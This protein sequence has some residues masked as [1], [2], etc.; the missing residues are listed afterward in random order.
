M[1]TLKYG[2][3]L[4]FL[5]TTITTNSG[6]EYEL[7]TL[8]WGYQAFPFPALY[9]TALTQRG[10]TI[11]GGS[12]Y[13]D[14]GH[15]VWINEIYKDYEN[16]TS[17]VTRSWF[18]YDNYTAFRPGIHI[19]YGFTPWAA[20]VGRGGMMIDLD[21]FTTPTGGIGLK[22]STPWQ[23]YACGSLIL[24]ADYPNLF[25]TT[26]L[27]GGVT[28]KGWELLTLG[29][30]SSV[31]EITPVWDKEHLL[32]GSLFFFA[33]LH[34]LKEMHILGGISPGLFRPSIY[35]GLGYTY[36]IAPRTKRIRKVIVTEEETYT[37]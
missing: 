24:E 36:N 1:N 5:L 22:L 12:A 33:N 18:N 6:Q 2:L 35:L 26:V 14:I 21:G 15:P 25:V 29:I 13:L 3:G 9:T 31:F 4:I 32:E 20:A 27:V 10:F 19:T 34:P 30:Q 17:C 28:A 23:K 11:G 16:D 7:D 37:E 8:D